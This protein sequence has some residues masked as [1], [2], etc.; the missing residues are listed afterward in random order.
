MRSP[1][2]Y[3]AIKDRAVTLLMSLPLPE[4]FNDRRS[5]FSGAVALAIA[6]GENVERAAGTYVNK[7]YVTKMHA[8]ILESITD[9]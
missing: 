2:G 4:D 8:E 3:N 5:W 1:K 7:R 9:V 6:L